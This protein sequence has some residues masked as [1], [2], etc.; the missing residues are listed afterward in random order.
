MNKLLT[1]YG[2][3]M[4][5]Q[6]SSEILEGKAHMALLPRMGLQFSSEIFPS[7]WGGWWGRWL[8]HP[9]FNS[10]LRS[11]HIQH[12]CPRLKHKPPKL[13]QFSFEILTLL[14]T[15]LGEISQLMPSFNSPLRSSDTSAICKANHGVRPSILFWDPPWVTLTVAQTANCSPSI[16]FWDPP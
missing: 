5:L 14:R 4:F 12:V 8:T 9:H 3:N 15:A 16:L 13:L 6:F 2:Y 10:P 7:R 1:K 11:S